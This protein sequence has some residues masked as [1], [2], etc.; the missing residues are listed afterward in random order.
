MFEII[1]SS[2][3]IVLSVGSLVYTVRLNNNRERKGHLQKNLDTIAGIEMQA[4]DHPEVLELHGIKK[5]EIVASGLTETQFAYLVCSFTAASIFFREN[6]FHSM[7]TF[8]KG[9][10]RYN[11]ISTEKFKKAWP[12]LKRMME[13]TDFRKKLEKYIESA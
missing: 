11:M 6:P 4:I 5:E 3:A 2:I 13:N 7:K 8:E 9:G 10:Y 1:F 12:L